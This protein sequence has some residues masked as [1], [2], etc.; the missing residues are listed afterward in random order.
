MNLVEGLL[1]LYFWTGLLF[2]IAFVTRGVD[3]LDA[4]AKGASWGFR[5]LIV[6]GTTALWPW[7][8][9]RRVRS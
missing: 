3:R 5:L 7:L 2:A 1:A 4:A 8:L 9:A 6:P